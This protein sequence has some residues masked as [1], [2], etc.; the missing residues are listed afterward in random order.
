MICSS[1][2]TQWPLI[3]I[4]L[5]GLVA[6]ARAL[7]PNRLPSQYVREQWTTETRFPG[8]AVNGIAQTADGYLWIGT[9]RGLIRFD[10]F[11][12]TPVS[13]TSIASASNASNVSILQ[14]LTDAGGKLW[15]RAQ[16]AYVVHQKDGKFES[17]GYGLPAITALSKDNDGGVLV[18][19]VEQ[20][21]FRFMGD[22]VQ[23]LAPIVVP[24]LP[25]VIS[26]AQ[27]ADGKIWMGTLGAGLFFLAGGR[28]TQVNAGLLDRKIDCLLAIGTDELWV[29]TGT[30][31]YRGNGNGFRRL[32]LPSFLGIVQVLSL[33]RDRDS[34]IWVGTTRGLLRINA[35]GISLSEEND[36]RG[37]GG[38]NVLF[39][40]R[41]GNLWIGGARGLGRI[42][43]SAFVTYSPVSDR[44][45][46]HNG[47][48]YVDPEGRTWFA[49]A[50]GGLYVL[51]N[52][53][54]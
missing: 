39:E 7:D 20:G 54:V 12:F 18:S 14:L 37:D 13:L 17:V 26:T 45:F 48:V 1:K 47:P 46:E 5:V 25:P 11:N 27:T 2:Q 52:G 42:R 44:R 53:R 9:D 4:V 15:I 16:G 35:K 24:G 31:L 10:G 6:D 23:K 34:N 38:I 36:L 30:G 32:E 43:D 41:E 33:L 29:G 51:Q 22:D 19:D 3:G 28:A 50:Q 49:P 40:D 21:T 8:G